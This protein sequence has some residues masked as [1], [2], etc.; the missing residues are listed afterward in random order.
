MRR[1]LPVSMLTHKSLA[2]PRVGMQ[3]PA[4]ETLRET[5][6]GCGS[7]GGGRY[8]LKVINKA[9]IVREKK[10]EY[11]KNERLLLDRLRHRGVVE[12]FF[13]FQDEA[14]LYMGLQCCQ[15]GELFSQIRRVG[16]APFCLCTWSAFIATQ[17]VGRWIAFW[18]RRKVLEGG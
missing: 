4:R 1:A 5:R 7:A 13:T 6:Q 2:E 11:I 14:Q 8:A 15:N 3:P 16:P 18:Y 12:L 9:R 10:V 17:A